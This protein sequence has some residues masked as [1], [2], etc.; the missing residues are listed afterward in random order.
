MYDRYTKIVLTVIAVCLLKI[1][2]ADLISPAEAQG[3]VQ[4]VAICDRNGSDCASVTRLPGALGAQL[5]VWP[6]EY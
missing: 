5:W 3:G 6:K 2:F 4:R 1:A